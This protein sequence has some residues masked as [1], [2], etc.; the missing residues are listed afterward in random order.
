MLIREKTGGKSEFD[1]EGDREGDEKHDDDDEDK[2]SG[3][4]SSEIAGDGGVV[5]IA[6]S[7]RP[8][9]NAGMTLIL[10]HEC[11]SLKTTPV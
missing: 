5:F 7:Q 10:W 3:R 1:E 2:V 4:D 6:A 9:R 11:A 8:Q